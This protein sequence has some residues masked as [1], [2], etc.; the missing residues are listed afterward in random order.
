MRQATRW[1]SRAT[2]AGLLVAF[3]VGATVGC[4]GAPTS[5]PVGGEGRATVNEMGYMV[6]AEHA[7]DPATTL[8]D[9]A[10]TPELAPLYTF[11]MQHPE[12]LSYIPCTCGCGPMGHN[13]VWNCFVRAIEADG[14][15]VFDQHAAGCQICQDI[16][17]D[18]MRLWQRGSPLSEIREAI[19][20]SYPGPK[21]PT[22]YPA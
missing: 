9:Y 16:T 13:S 4:S 22:E 12:V 10:S 20:A 6:H 17:R 15:V 8:P 5:G 19:D 11:A 21:T 14:T 7:A 18:A 3:P 1:I 2:L